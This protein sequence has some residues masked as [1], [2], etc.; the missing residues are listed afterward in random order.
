MDGDLLVNRDGVR[1]VSQ[2]QS[3]TILGI[4]LCKK[5]P[6]TY[7]PPL[8]VTGISSPGLFCNPFFKSIFY[9]FHEEFG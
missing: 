5:I 6:V 9:M 2:S 4:L 8:L 3:D 7:K 1:I